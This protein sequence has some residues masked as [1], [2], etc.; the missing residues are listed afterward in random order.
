M[1]KINA[2]RIKIAIKTSPEKVAILWLKFTTFSQTHFCFSLNLFNFHARHDFSPHFLVQAF[3]TFMKQPSHRLSIPRMGMNIFVR[4]CQEKPYTLR[5]SSIHYG[6]DWSCFF[7]LKWKK[8]EHYWW[9]ML[10]GYFFPVI[11]LTSVR[12]RVQK[13]YY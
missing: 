5:I 1:A 7:H 12:K 8:V 2:T 6:N 13:S 9:F 10:T 11:F 3:H 4:C